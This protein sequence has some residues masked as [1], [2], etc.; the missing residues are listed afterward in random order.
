[1][2]LTLQIVRVKVVYY[3]FFL[4]FFLSPIISLIILFIS[5][6][7]GESN[8]KKPRHLIQENGTCEIYFENG[9]IWKKF[10]LSNGLFD[11]KYE[12]FTISGGESLIMN[13]KNGK[14]HGQSSLFSKVRNCYKY[15]EKFENGLL[16]SSQSMVRT[17]GHDPA[18]L[19]GRKYELA[20]VVV[21]KEDLKEIGSSIKKI[22]LEP[23]GFDGEIDRLRKVGVSFKLLKD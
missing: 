2:L 23:K 19:T 22:D 20:Q 16:I 9:K 8:E 3:T 7:S 14:L 12:S 4:S 10:N 21:N 1:V 11:G 6:E 5:N 15:I 18:T 13:F 17:E